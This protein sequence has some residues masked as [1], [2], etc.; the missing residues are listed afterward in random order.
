LRA[1][2]IEDDREQLR[3]TQEVLTQS[4]FEVTS[5]EDVDSFLT[6][7]DLIPRPVD[8]IV[9]DRRLPKL[10]G[11]EPQDHI[12]DALLEELL[13]IFR[14]VPIVV[15]TGYTG[16][17]HAQFATKDRGVI[18]MS[19]DHTDFLDR[20]YHYQKDQTIQFGNL[21]ARMA[22]RIKH[23]DA[24]NVNCKLSSDPPESIPVTKRV[25]R[26]V[27][28]QFD[29]E[30]ITASRM[31]GGL[32]G[33]NVWS[34]DIL[35]KNGQVT[36]RLVV[37]DA[38]GEPRKPLGLHN[39]LPAGSIAALLETVDGLMDGRHAQVMQLAGDSNDSLLTL[40]QKDPLEAAKQIDQLKAIFDQGVKHQTRIIDL[41]ELVRPLISW[42]D[43]SQR[44]QDH[45]LNVP[46]SDL[47]VQVEQGLQHGDLHGANV[48]VVNG[49]PVLID[50][51]SATTASITLDPLT[52][53]LSYFFHRE[54]SIRQSE[55][56]SL[57][58]I[59]A[60]P[61]QPFLNN[62]PYFEWMSKLILWL[63]S[64]E[65]SER[66]LWG[67]VLAYSVR[68]LKYDDVKTVPEVQARA[69]AFARKAV[70]ELRETA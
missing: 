45:G 62:C 7:A 8:L 12:G 40:I 63:G 11:E 70:T 17:P 37:K 21:V 64:I 60:F 52:L 48:L 38:R 28:A 34:C 29:G 53:L 16:I 24:I 41:Q 10:V 26:R 43:L 51:D 61:E 18:K 5:Y 32:G 50:F 39:I 19:G 22:S 67:L 31:T 9:T 55:W 1:I 30:S 59:E 36:S 47:R 54:S 68:Q 49:S 66:E 15:F 6:D 3:W 27:A 20:V 13:R 69:L 42:G 46:D 35:S 56:P 2:L 44:L 25:L 57:P 23:I 33:A 65:Y 14:D 4:S 58:E